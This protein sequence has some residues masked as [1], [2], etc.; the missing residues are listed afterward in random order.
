MWTITPYVGRS[1]TDLYMGT[2]KFALS[3]LSGILVGATGHSLE[4]I[5]YKQTGFPKIL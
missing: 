3:E 1:H 2:K 5:S 4:H